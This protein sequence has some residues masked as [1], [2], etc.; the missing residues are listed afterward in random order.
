MQIDSTGDKGTKANGRAIEECPSVGA[1]ETNREPVNTK[2]AVKCTKVEESAKPV[3]EGLKIV[4]EKLILVP[5]SPKLVADS[6][7][8]ESTAEI[9]TSG[10]QHENG[11]ES[12]EGGSKDGGGE[13]D[14]STSGKDGDDWD[15]CYKKC[16]SATPH[17]YMRLL[18]AMPHTRRYFMA[19]ALPIQRDRKRVIGIKGQ[20][21]VDN[22]EG[23]A[24]HKGSSSTRK[25]GKRHGGVCEGVVLS[26]K[27]KQRERH[28]ISPANVVA[29]AAEINKECKDSVNG[30]ETGM[31]VCLLRKRM[32]VDDA[33]Q[34]AV[35]AGHKDVA[36]IVQIGDSEKAGHTRDCGEAMSLSSFTLVRTT[37]GQ[38]ARNLDVIEK[39]L[40]EGMGNGNKMDHEHTQN[41]VRTVS[42]ILKHNSKEGNGLKGLSSVPL[43]S[44]GLYG[45]G[46]N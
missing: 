5:E 13:G 21:Q 35:V 27:Q 26:K 29:E 36:E 9:D 4:S 22:G 3:S 43:Q 42:P 2:A 25:D 41:G 28:D 17:S 37:A 11:E 44:N 33:C 6:L 45:L 32:E 40:V 18:Y 10:I 14:C 31:D 24:T 19:R 12:T 1:V 15:E 38:Q 39:V 20:G 7:K 46:G 16:N 30:N 34:G 23:E 8:V